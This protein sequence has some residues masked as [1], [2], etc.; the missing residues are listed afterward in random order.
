MSE[1]EPLTRV[2]LKHLPVAPRSSLVQHKSQSRAPHSK[3]TSGVWHEEL[4]KDKWKK[5]Q[6]GCCG[7][8]SAREMLSESHRLLS[9]SSAGTSLPQPS[10]AMSPADKEGGVS[11]IISCHAIGSGSSSCQQ[12]ALLNT[13]C[14][15]RRD[16]CQKMEMSP[17][18]CPG[19]M[20]HR[21]PPAER[22][23]LG[24]SAS[25]GH[26]WSL[27]PRRRQRHCW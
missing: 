12:Q 25:T 20:L 6:L 14:K 5:N 26:C 9:S 11:Q 16:P 3:V 21:K 10:G 13:R 1:E 19:A 24:C 18:K 15:A 22:G 17:T 8:S 7:A 23:S 4:V 27:C 2:V